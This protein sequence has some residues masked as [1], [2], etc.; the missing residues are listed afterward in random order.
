MVQQFLLERL[1]IEGLV[2]VLFVLRK[3]NWKGPPNGDPRFWKA[4]GTVQRFLSKLW[5][6]S[7]A[8]MRIPG[9]I[10]DGFDKPKPTQYLYLHLRDL[11]CL[12]TL[13]QQAQTPA[14]FFKELESTYM[15]SLIHET[16]I[17]VRVRQYDGSLTFRELSEGE[18]QLLT[19]VGLIRFTREAESLFL[20]DEPDT[21]LN[22]AWG[23]EYLEIL[24][25]IADTGN[26]SQI[27][28]ATHDPLMIAGLRKQQVLVLERDG[29]TGR[30]IAVHPD[31]DPRGMGVSGI[32][33]SSMFGLRTTLDLPTQAKLDE[34]FELAAKEHRTQQEG[35]RLR[36]LSEELA[37]A[38]FAQDFRD[39][40]YQRYASAIAKVRAAGRRILTHEEI[41]EIEEEALAAVEKISK[42]SIGK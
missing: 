13:A 19:V 6:M 30:I 40:N 9:S 36:Q 4:A 26:D 23:M 41:R 14:D 20:L 34:R 5:D 27:I 2:S 39:D 15:S 17:R 38:G 18:Q 21:H 10:P 31:I 22:P 16:R 12:R 33:K 29:S 3:P 8:P 25:E 42:Q 11:D 24:R 37:D 32:L 28:I 35:E 1:G 7:L